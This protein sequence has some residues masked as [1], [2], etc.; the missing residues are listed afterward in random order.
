M[1]RHDGVL[2][3]MDK[4]YV[5]GKLKNEEKIYLTSQSFEELDEFLQIK[6]DLCK[7]E[8]E[9]KSFHYDFF[10]PDEIQDFKSCIAIVLDNKATDLEEIEDA[11]LFKKTAT[12]DT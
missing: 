4:D 5:I 2:K 12:M 10:I 3:S 11:K 8:F 1:Y 9:Y 7:V 6:G